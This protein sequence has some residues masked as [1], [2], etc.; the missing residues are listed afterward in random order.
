MH[1]NKAQRLP[2]SIAMLTLALPALALAEPERDGSATKTPIK[3]V[4]VIF[5]ENVSF[6]HYFGTYPNAAP[7]KDG[8]RYFRGA[9]PDT[10]RVNSLVSA[11]LL[12]NNP[13]GANPFHVSIA[14]FPTPATRTTTTT[15]SSS[16]FTAA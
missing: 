15:T 5:Q 7:N 6:D 1:R 9:S 13:N 12:T 2:L 8:S 11:G 4:V 3:H 14:A 16:P 10:P